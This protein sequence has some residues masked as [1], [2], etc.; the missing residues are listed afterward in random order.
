MK[1][2]KILGTWCP[3]CLKL[4]SN[5]KLALEQTWIKAN[6]EKITDI[7]DIMWYWIMG[8]PWIVINEKVVSYWKVNEVDEIIKLIK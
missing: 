3:N 2:I 6:I 4:E 7:T 1:T 5:V 8:T